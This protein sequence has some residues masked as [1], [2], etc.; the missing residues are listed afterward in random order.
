M[1]RMI[2]RLF[3]DFLNL[4][5]VLVF[6]LSIASFFVDPLWRYV[7]AAAP[8]HAGRALIIFGLLL[9]YVIAAGFLSTVV[10]INDNL[11]EL[12]RNLARSAGKGE[13]DRHEPELRKPARREPAML[14]AH[15]P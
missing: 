2:A 11:E 9:S 14:R 7:F 12:N 5:H 1:N 10:A 3:S 8:S 15:R 6:S 4:L 13:P